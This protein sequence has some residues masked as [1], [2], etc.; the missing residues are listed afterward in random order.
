VTDY[1]ETDFYV[2]KQPAKLSS[3][4]E[5][6]QFGGFWNDTSS[7]QAYI[8]EDSCK[9][10]SGPTAMYQWVWTVED[11]TGDF[12]L[13]QTENIKCVY[14]ELKNVPLCPFSLC[15]DEQCQF[16]LGFTKPKLVIESDETIIQSGFDVEL[17]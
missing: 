15:R 1:T 11:F 8:F 4:Y 14:Q 16:C 12:Y 9:S 2:Y 7:F 13:M 3:N 17:A 10:F 6:Q 5:E